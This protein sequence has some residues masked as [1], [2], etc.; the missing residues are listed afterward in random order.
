MDVIRYVIIYLW[1]HSPLLVLGRFNLIF[2]AVGKTPWTGD[3]AVARPLPARRKAQTQNKRTQTST[4]Q[5]AFESKVPVFEWA[6]TI[7]GL[8]RAAVVIGRHIIIDPSNVVRI[9]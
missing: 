5:V 7:H 2:Y 3:Q 6:K 9:T 1:F 8:D 4:P